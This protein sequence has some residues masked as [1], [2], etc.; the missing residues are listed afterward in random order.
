MGNQYAY[1][2]VS[3]K[4]QNEE[5]QRAAMLEYGVPAK[6]IILDKQSGKDFERQGYKRLMKKLKRGD[7][8]IIKSIDRLG[9]NYHEILEQWRILTKEKE[10]AI[11]V[12]DMPLL[13]TRQ[14]R[15]LTGVL[16]ADIV[17][18]LLSYVAE[19]ERKFIRQRQAEGIAAARARGANL[20]RRPKDRPPEFAA[21]KAAWENGEI[22]ARSAAR[23]LKINHMTFKRW[24]SNC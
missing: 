20:G 1:I 4:E 2:R 23:R 13:D 17:L 18:Q 3:S 7:I 21:V 15:D 14:N 22:S 8:L 9:R 16:I 19:T 24:A 12:L 10:A 11:V 5:R 6:N